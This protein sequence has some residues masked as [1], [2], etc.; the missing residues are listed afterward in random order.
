MRFDMGLLRIL[1]GQS[2]LRILIHLVDT[3]FLLCQLPATMTEN[4]LGTGVGE[5]EVLPILRLE[6]AR[7]NVDDFVWLARGA[8]ATDFVSNPF[9]NAIGP[10]VDPGLS[11]G[12]RPRK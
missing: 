1:N 9:F 8:A 5:T 2:G 4:A 10:S 11:K 7:F 3:A 12:Y 6:L